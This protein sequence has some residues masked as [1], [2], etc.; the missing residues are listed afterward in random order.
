MKK[1]LFAAAAVLALSAPANAAFVA[2]LG[3]DPSVNF[4]NTSAG[5]FED[6]YSFSLAEASVLTIVSATNTFAGGIGS[7][8]FIANFTGSVVLN[9]D[10]IIGNLDDQIVVGPIGATLGCGPITL[11]QGFAGSALLAGGN[12]Y[13]DVSGVG[14][15]NSHYGGDITTQ[16]AVP[17]PSTWALMIVGFAGIVFMGAARKRRN[18]TGRAFRLV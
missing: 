18:E 13:L 9:P 12:Y 3:A 8:Q 15:S 6:F 14:G 7:N 11:C 17:E 5:A 16:A 10:G 2:N 1:L 4:G